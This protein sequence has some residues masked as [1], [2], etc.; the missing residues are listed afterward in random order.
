ME[1]NSSRRQ[2][3]NIVT[4]NGRDSALQRVEETIAWRRSDQGSGSLWKCFYRGMGF[5]RV[6]G[7]WHNPIPDM[8]PTTHACTVENL[9]EEAHTIDNLC[10]S[11]VETALASW[12]WALA[13]VSQFRSFTALVRQPKVNLGQT[14][15]HETLKGRGMDRTWLFE[16]KPKE[17]SNGEPLG[18]GLQTIYTTVHEGC[19]RLSIG[20]CTVHDIIVELRARLLTSRVAVCTAWGTGLGYHRIRCADKILHMIR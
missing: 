4:I 5:C 3:G 6:T 12:R 9:A 20:L 17:C 2:K 18:A 15:T 16:H 19:A 13:L 8:T 1:G 7:L 11:A 10:Q 14:T